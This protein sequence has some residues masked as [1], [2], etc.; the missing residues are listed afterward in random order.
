VPEG[1]T[2]HRAANH[3]R[4]LLLGRPIRALELTRRTESTE[5]LIGKTVI[6][7]EARGKNLLVHIDGGFSL[8]VHLKMNGWVYA[9]RHSESRRPGR[10]TVVVL[11][12]DEHRVLVDSAPVARLIRTADLVRD[13][14]FRNL[15]PDLLAGTFELDEALAR[16]RI[17]KEVP[18]GEALMDQSAVAGI[19]NVW[20]SELCF[21][22]KLDPFAPVA[23]ATDEELRA[24]LELA[25]KQMKETVERAPRRIPDPFTARGGQRQTRTNHRLGQKRTSVYERGGE[26]CYDC[27][28]KIEMKRQGAQDR[29]TYFCPKCQPARSY[30]SSTMLTPT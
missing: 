12:T 22:L 6:G 14:H 16:L 1:D 24:L 27:S 23:A 11:D 18:L 2:L 17:R 21:N 8:H 5:G 3:L 7:V 26:P 25:Q 20:K 29:S 4:P 15:G 30:S 10:E 9:A 19:G 13:I 28:T